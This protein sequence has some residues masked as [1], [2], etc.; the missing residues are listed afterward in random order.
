MNRILIVSLSVILCLLTTGCGNFF[1]SESGGGGVASRPSNSVGL[2]VIAVSPTSTL[3]DTSA[4][5]AY[6]TYGSFT[7]NGLTTSAGGNPNSAS[8][9]SAGLFYFIPN[10]VPTTS[11]PL[12]AGWAIPRDSGCPTAQNPGTYGYDN[13]SYTALQQYPIYNCQAKPSTQLIP[14]SGDTNN[15]PGGMTMVVNYPI[16]TT[17]GMPQVGIYLTDGTYVGTET[18]SS[19]SS[20]GTSISFP[21]DVIPYPA[22]PKNPNSNGPYTVYALSLVQIQSDGTFDPWGGATVS[23]HYAPP[24][25]CNP[26]RGCGN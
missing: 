5:T 9:T 4:T 24:P 25:Q 10:I 18:A 26:Q 22:T 6:Y 11:S 21:T 7:T 19:V 2:N 23:L 8:Y 12:A 16:S 3:T 15:W 20:D 13:L 14:T 1:T 17:Y